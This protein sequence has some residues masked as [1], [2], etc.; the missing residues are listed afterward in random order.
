MKKLVYGALIFVA[1]LHTQAQTNSRISQ[2]ATLGKVWGFLKYYHPA[3]AKGKPDWDSVLLQMIPLVEEVKTGKAL[4]SLF[5]SWY[6]SLPTATLSVTRVNWK[7]DS[8]IR[9]FTEKDIQQF[10]VSAWLKK[11]LVRLYQYHMPDTNRYATRYYGG[12]YYDHIIHD[13]AAFD[14]PACP[15]QPVRLLTLFRYWNTINYFYPHKDHLPAWDTVLTGYIPR[16]LQADNAAQYQYVVRQLIHELRDSHSF[17]QPRGLYF[18]PFH[19]D[20]IERK[21][22]IT[23]C[24]DSIA[25]KWDYRPG[26]EI[27]AVNGKD[28]RQREKELLA[29]TTGTNSLSLYRNIAYELL[30]GEDSVVQVGF[31]RNGNVFTKTVG[32]LG[33]DAYL[34]I[35]KLAEKPLWQQLDKGIWY[36]RFCRITNADTLRQLFSDIRQAKAVIWDMRDY[37][38]FKVT[39]ELYKYFFP[40]KTLFAELRNSWDYYPGTFVKSPMHFIPEGREELIYNGPLIVLIDEHTQS[41]AESVASALKVRTNTITMGRQTAGTTGNI[42][43]LTLPG[44]IEVSYTGVGVAGAQRSFREVKGVQLDIPV[45]LDQAGIMQRRD[46]ILEQAMQYARK[47]Y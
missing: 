25:K 9:I 42:T 13:E 1:T 23:D 11:E 34:Q 33:F 14:K 4:D 31:K 38:N 10:R 43:W 28:C 6:R 15:M 26:D 37:P 45:T 19:V 36:V 22:L 21:Y 16:F 5:D 30:R 17:Y 39:T 47:Y 24:N 2:L 8:L 18:T 44:G 27:I 46:Y 32:M 35:A 20:Y 40:A 41:L 12:Y 29:V 3:V 7:A